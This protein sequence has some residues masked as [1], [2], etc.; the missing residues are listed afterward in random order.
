MD[1]MKNRYYY[2]D[3]LMHFLKFL[4]VKHSRKEVEVCILSSEY[5][6][7]LLSIVETLF[8]YGVESDAIKGDIQTLRSLSNPCIA[9]LQENGKT[10]FVVFVSYSNGIVNIYDARQ[11][12]NI[13]L[14][15]DDIA[16]LWTGIIVIP[17]STPP[18]GK[19]NQQWNKVFGGIFLI[20]VFFVECVWFVPDILLSY[21]LL[22][23]MGI[24][25]SVPLVRQSFGLSNNGVF[26]DFCKRGGVIDCESVGH[27]KLAKIGGVSLAEISLTYFSFR[28]FLIILGRTIEIDQVL[29]VLALFS[30]LGLF[31]AILSVLYQFTVVKKWCLFCLG[32][33]FVVLL[34]NCLDLY[35]IQRG[36]MPTQ[37]IDFTAST[38]IIM[39]FVFS[40][41]LLFII[42]YVLNLE[43]KKNE[44]R[45]KLLK[46]Q[47]NTNVLRAIIST[48]TKAP[49]NQF[50]DLTIGNSGADT[51]VTTLISPYCPKCADVIRIMVNLLN[52][53]PRSIL[54]NIRLDGILE[55]QLSPINMCQYDL[56]SKLKETR[57]IDN[58]LS[59]I[60]K[61]NKSK[62]NKEFMPP[63]FYWDEYQLH[64]SNNQLFSTNKVPTIWLDD[65]ELSSLIE[66]ETLSTILFRKDFG[67][68]SL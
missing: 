58:Q 20:T 40:L 3:L 41:T 5:Y 49:V 67:V 15:E 62:P 26:S 36:C 35:F 1:S 6:P 28:V 10:W 57:D 14:T 33:A 65:I 39:S 25:L 34:E 47:R 42:R 38:G 23:L 22:C 11:H 37:M 60:L 32:I 13:T 21:L 59:L 63:S 31:V 4:G 43:K 44:D 55:S 66:L 19:T 7:S 53:H 51:V 56:Y 68:L 16:N 61:W 2:T 9:Q 8:V 46:I 29:Q 30:L 50:Q 54:W 12:K 52:K 27:S 24:L 48:S 64:I 18:R 45:L 17:T